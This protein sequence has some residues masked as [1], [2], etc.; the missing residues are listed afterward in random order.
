MP[1]RTVDSIQYW[2]TFFL[3]SFC[4]IASLS[5]SGGAARNLLT[6]NITRGPFSLRLMFPSC[7]DMDMPFSFV[8]Q[9][10]INN[11][12]SVSDQQPMACECLTP[13][14]SHRNFVAEW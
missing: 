6:S 13:S 4:F 7:K 11:G 8:A 10:A 12:S 9:T 1:H 3:A 5:R 2:D 14:R